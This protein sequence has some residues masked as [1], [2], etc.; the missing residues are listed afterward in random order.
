MPAEGP[1]FYLGSFGKKSDT[2]KAVNSEAKRPANGDE[3]TSNHR[4]QA[5][6][7]KALLKEVPGDTRR[8]GRGEYTRD[9]AAQRHGK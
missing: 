1:V 3:V 7:R 5:A 6:G 4:Q 2:V 9:E 8:K